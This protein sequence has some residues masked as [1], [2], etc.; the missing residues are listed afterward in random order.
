MIDDGV[1]SLIDFGT[2]GVSVMVLG[3]A[4]VWLVRRGY[5]REDHWIERTLEREREAAEREAKTA[6]LMTRVLA[7]LEESHGKRGG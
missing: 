6:D 1:R 4:V 5:T 2:L 7:F 3:A